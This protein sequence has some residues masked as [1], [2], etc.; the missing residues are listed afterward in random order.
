MIEARV[1]GNYEGLGFYAVPSQESISYSL[2][3]M[4][5]MKQHY[6]DL[7]QRFANT[8]IAEFA[9]NVI[10]G[11][12]EIY[13]NFL[14]SD[15]IR[16]A[17]AGHRKIAALNRDNEIYLAN[18]I[19]DIQNSPPIM[20]RYNMANPTARQWM[21]DQRTEAYGD[22]Y[23][24]V[25]GDAIGNNH[26]DYR[27]V[28]DNRI[29]ED[30]DKNGVAVYRHTEYLDRIYTGDRKLDIMEKVLIQANWNIIDKAFDVGVEDPL[31]PDNEWL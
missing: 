29:V 8:G 7:S 25:H 30:V 1:S 16:L 31:S 11:A 26:Y 5:K 14:S 21:F 18:N 28:M 4:D 20:I 3:V 19:G 24:N 17:K 6:G 2:S 9:N 23:N 22:R 13:Q 15:A 27:R 12:Q 10:Q